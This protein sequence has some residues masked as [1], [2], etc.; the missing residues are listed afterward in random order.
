MNVGEMQR[1]LSLWAE[2]DKEH[3]FFDLYHLLYDMDWLQLAHDYVKQNKGNTT[4]GCDG[5]NMSQFDENLE[6]NLSQIASELKTETFQ[7]Y[8]V[9][10]V[11]ILKKKSGKKRPLG[12]PS[13]RD[14]IVQ[15]AVRMIL[16]PIYEA[17]FSQRSFGFRP[18]RCTMNAI[19]YITLN[20]IGRAKYHWMIEGDISSYFDTIKHRQLI[21]LLRKRI[22]DGKLLWLIQKF[23]T[24]GVMENKL[25]R[26]IE[27]GTPQGGIC[28]PLLAN[29]YLHEL[30]K[31]IEGY[32]NIPAYEK[33]KRKKRGEPNFAYARYADDFV[34]L[35]NGT[36][37]EAEEIKEKLKKYSKTSGPIYLWLPMYEPV[38]PEGIT[39]KQKLEDAMHTICVKT[40]QQKS[41]L[42]SLAEVISNLGYN[43]IYA[44]A[45]TEGKQ[46]VVN[47]FEKSRKEWI[48]S[49]GLTK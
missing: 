20:T 43:I 39:A 36:K 48:K 28:S 24:A 14:R 34:I 15:Q 46:S 33:S 27:M 30:D 22:K 12:I 32:T 45:T 3:R 47:E 17:D 5:I 18:C 2:Q 26:D 41:S 42:E 1:K 11:Y 7:P 23:L 37:T 4:A 38:T 10:R 44:T 13:I 29:I 49:Q 8:P 6:E 31:Y 19:N 16:E 21:K 35:V 25:F 9:R 40:A